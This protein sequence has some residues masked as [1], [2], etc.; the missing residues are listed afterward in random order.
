MTNCKILQKSGIPHSAQTY[1]QSSVTDLKYSHF[2]HSTLENVQLR[3]LKV[4]NLWFE[5]F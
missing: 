5:D 1:L 2:H 4:T 3:L